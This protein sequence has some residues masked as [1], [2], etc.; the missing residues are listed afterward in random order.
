MPDFI[1]LAGVAT[2]HKDDIRFPEGD[3]IYCHFC[4]VE[5]EHL[6]PQRMLPHGKEGVL[7]CDVCY[8]T[9]AGNYAQYPEQATMLG[10]MQVVAGV[11][12]MIIKEIRR[13]AASS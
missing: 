9:F 4:G 13:N 6:H 7:L 10:L 11:G 12:N 5:S 3:K 2:R 1:C 8:C